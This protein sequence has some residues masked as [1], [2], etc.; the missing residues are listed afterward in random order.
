PDRRPAATP[1]PRSPLPLEAQ[2]LTPAPLE[3]DR[4]YRHGQL[5][6]HDH[7][8]ASRRAA[9]HR[10]VPASDSTAWPPTVTAAPH[11]SSVTMLRLL[12]EVVA[13][14]HRQHPR[15]PARQKLPARAHLL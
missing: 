15:R 4:G 10:A 1:R 11:P 8:P 7:A 6:D 2:G 5:G 9:S 3:L 14:R 12:E 13:L